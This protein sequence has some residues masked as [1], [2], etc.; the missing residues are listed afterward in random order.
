M[1]ALVKFQHGTKFQLG[2]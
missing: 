1:Y 2:R